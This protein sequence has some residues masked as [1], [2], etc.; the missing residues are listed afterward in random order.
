MAPA[1]NNPVFQSAATDAF[2]AQTIRLGRENTPMPAF[3]RAGF[4]ESDIGD[5][6][7]FIRT[8]APAVVTRRQP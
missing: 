3:A 4:E 7:A 6:L 2:I 8:W 5:L 1:L